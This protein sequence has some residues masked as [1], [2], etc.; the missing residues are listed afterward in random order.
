MIRAGAALLLLLALA[1]P[2][3]RAAADLEVGLED[4]RIMLDSP[5]RAEPVARQWA[6]LGADAV[7]IHARWRDRRDLAGLD[8]AVNAAQAAGLKVQLTITGRVHRPDPRRYARFAG[9]VARR[10]RGRIVRY[11]IWNEPNI[12]GW[13]RPQA[14]CRRGRC[15]PVSPHLY[16]ALARAAVPAVHAADP[17]ATVLVGELAP[18]GDALTSSRSTVAPLRFLRALACVDR[19]LRPVTRGRCARFRPVAADGFGHHPHGQHASPTNVSSNPD[20]AKIAELGRVL[21]LLDRL[22]G[23]RRM[24]APGGRFDLWLTEF[25]Y[26]T[27]PPDRDDG[28]RLARQASWLQ[29]AAYRAWRDPRIRSL[30]LYQWEDEPTYTRNPGGSPFAGWQ[31]GLRFADGRP[32]PALRGV[33]VPFVVD[34]DRGRVWGQ[35]RPGGAHTVTLQRRG[36]D[37]WAP[38]GGPIATDERGAF[39]MP[40]DLRTGDRLRY[41]TETG[42]RSGAARV[43]ARGVSAPRR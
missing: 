14:R 13:L 4:E 22:T 36:P 1:A 40:V 10:Y 15:V 16:R 5:G 29:L 38:L 26:Q 9:E 39:L 2:A 25:S 3:A 41:V 27:D 32:K 31:S 8:A 24:L 11:L 30:T 43:P 21:R 28:V 12:Q 37:G 6:R 20:W 18:I 17:G 23:A 35:V 42:G 19:A 7:R 34:R 33:R